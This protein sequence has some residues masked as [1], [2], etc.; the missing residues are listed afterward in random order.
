MP[1]TYIRHFSSAQQLRY[2]QVSSTNENTMLREVIFPKHTTAKCLNQ[3]P[4][5]CLPGHGSLFPVSLQAAHAL[6][7]PHALGQRDTWQ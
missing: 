1:T 5:P 4:D 2:K 6:S 7:Q 3:H